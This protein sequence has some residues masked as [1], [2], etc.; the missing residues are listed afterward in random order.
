MFAPR[1]PSTNHQLP[2]SL[3]PSAGDKHL[4]VY[5]QVPLPVLLPTPVDPALWSPQCDTPSKVTPA[6]LPRHE[7]PCSLCP[8][9][10]AS[11]PSSTPSRSSLVVSLYPRSSIYIYIISMKKI[12]LFICLRKSLRVRAHEHVALDSSH[13]GSSIS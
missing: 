10:V 7:A 9:A 3:W 5:A 12:K 4:V 6:S 2:T 13:R 11:S 1:L 8:S